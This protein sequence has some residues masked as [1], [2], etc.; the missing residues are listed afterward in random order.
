MKITD[1][2]QVTE[3][4]FKPLYQRKSFVHDNSKFRGLEVFE[5]GRIGLKT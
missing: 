1:M 4:N 3:E 5:E 2:L